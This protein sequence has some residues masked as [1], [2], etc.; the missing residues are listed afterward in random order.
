M[1]TLKKSTNSFFTIT[2]IMSVKHQK[3]FEQGI[4]NTKRSVR[5]FLVFFG[6]IV[7]DVLLVRLFAMKSI[8]FQFDNFLESCFE[9]SIPLSYITE[10]VNYF[11][12]DF[13]Y[14]AINTITYWLIFGLLIYVLNNKLQLRKIFTISTVI[15]VTWFYKV[16]RDVWDGLY[17]MQSFNEIVFGNGYV[18]ISLSCI[19]LAMVYFERIVYK[20]LF[21]FI[22][23]ILI[24]AYENIYTLFFNQLFILKCIVITLFTLLFT[25][26]EVISHKK[27]TKKQLQTN[28]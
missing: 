18:I 19:V 22:S 7:T 28:L 15:L 9:N 11:S 8:A 3:S 24:L 27:N 4:V 14:Q 10:P 1:L 16:F 23:L 20:T 13:F 5:L 21:L 2:Y 12:S 17:T 26:I 6:A 25:V